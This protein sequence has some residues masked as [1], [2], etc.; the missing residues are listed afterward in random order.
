MKTQNLKNLVDGVKNSLYIEEVYKQP[1]SVTLS[2]FGNNRAFEKNVM[3][4]NKEYEQKLAAELIET[5]GEDYHEGPSKLENIKKVK[6]D[7]RLNLVNATFDP[8]TRPC[9]YN[10]GSM[11]LR[12]RYGAPEERFTT[13]DYRTQ[14]KDASK[15]TKVTQLPL[16]PEASSFETNFPKLKSSFI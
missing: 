6:G 5:H 3:E 2:G 11:D 15:G 9:P 10:S 1:F 8:N 12:W 7:P 14:I 16:L 4:L 13:E